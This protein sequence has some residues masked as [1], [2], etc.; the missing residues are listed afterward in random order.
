MYTTLGLDNH[1]AQYFA[2]RPAPMGAVTAKV[3]AA[4]FYNFN[5]ELIAMAIP[6]A[7]DIASPEAV[8]R[9][10]YEIVDEVLA[11]TKRAHVQKMGFV[12][13]EY[14]MNVF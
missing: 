4:T 7:W 8:T 3:V 6:A 12:G 9:M 10:R 1:C 2:S 13:N 5:P 14:Y 11:V